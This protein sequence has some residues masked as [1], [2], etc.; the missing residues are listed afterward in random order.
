MA[1]DTLYAIKDAVDLTLTPLGGSGEAITIDYLN[2]FNTSTT[3]E[4][5][6]AR[7]KGVDKIVLYSA[8]TVEFTLDSETLTKPAMALMVG[9][10][11]DK[12]SDKITVT[13]ATRVQ[14]FSMTGTF[15]MV[16]ENGTEEVMTMTAGKV[17][18]VP[19]AEWGMDATAI[20]T[21]SMKLT[22]MQDTD[23]NMFTIA[24]KTTVSSSA[25]ASDEVISDDPQQLSVKK[26]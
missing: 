5:L 7:A 4:K 24:K 11:Y 13:G 17:A 9:G 18:T 3:S 25:K 23:G 6:S 26:K 12:A 22:V 15:T 10:T 20:S 1:K 14:Y 21:F 2:T 16:A 19:E 8:K